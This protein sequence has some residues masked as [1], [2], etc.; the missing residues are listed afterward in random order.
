MTAEDEEEFLECDEV[1]EKC[2]SWKPKVFKPIIFYLHFLYSVVIIIRIS[3][4]Y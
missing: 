2:F 4:T 3:S 1:P